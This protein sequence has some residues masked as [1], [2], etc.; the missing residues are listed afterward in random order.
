MLQQDNPS[1][2]VIGTGESHSV[3]EFVEFAFKHVG[4]E[5]EWKGKGIDEKGIVCS[6]ASNLQPPTSN[7]NQ[8][9]RYHY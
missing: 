6:L 2:Y 3:R 1:D 8:Y 7:R 4:V 9:R 5:L